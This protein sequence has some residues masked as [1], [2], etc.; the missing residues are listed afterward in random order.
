[1]LTPSRRSRSLEAHFNWVIVARK[2]AM[3][4]DARSDLVAARVEAEASESGVDIVRVT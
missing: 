4:A 3:M 1:M 2:S